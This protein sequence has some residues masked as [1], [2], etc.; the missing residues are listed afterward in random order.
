MRLFVAIRLPPCVVERLTLLRTELRDFD[1]V[2]HYTEKTGLHITLAFLGDISDDDEEILSTALK[3]AC[4]D[5]GRLSLAIGGGGSFPENDA[6]Q[7]LWLRVEGQVN[8]LRDL[9]K[10]VLATLEA[11]SVPLG[12]RPFSPHVSIAR[13]SRTANIVDRR[14]LTGIASKIDGYD[15]GIFDVHEIVVLA[16]NLVPKGAIYTPVSEIPL[17]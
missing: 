2:L 17:T 15:A 6:A 3:S 14:R 16:S 1:D 13:V 9:H 12:N 7:V 4:T 5:F 10:L 11:Q 8:R